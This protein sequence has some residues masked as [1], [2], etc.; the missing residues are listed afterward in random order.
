MKQFLKWMFIL[1]L[2]GLIVGF[3]FLLIAFQQGQCDEIGNVERP[4][5]V[6]DD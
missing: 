2:S 4:G 3:L 5:C 1:I 6:L